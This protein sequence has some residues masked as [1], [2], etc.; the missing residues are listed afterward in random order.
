MLFG[1]HAAY[2]AVAT[3]WTVDTVPVTDVEVVVLTVVLKIVL[4]VLL[5]SVVEASTSITV[6]VV[7]IVDVMVNELVWATA[8][9]VE[10]VVAVRV[11]VAIGTTSRTSLQLTLVGN[12]ACLLRVMLD[13]HLVVAAFIA[14]FARG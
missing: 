1:A 5:V 12:V 10:V 7:E 8:V 11:V 6:V 3:G 9:N 2:I 4:V 14:L 13:I